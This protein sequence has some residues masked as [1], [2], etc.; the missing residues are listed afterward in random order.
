L[1]AWWTLSFLNRLN[2]PLAKVLD[3]FVPILVGVLVYFV[4]VKLLK[5]E[6]FEWIV[7]RRKKS[8]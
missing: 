4:F 1:A 3:V 5:S 7:S 6:S 2:I 8:V